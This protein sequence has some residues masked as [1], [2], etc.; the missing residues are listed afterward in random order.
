[1]KSRLL[2]LAAVAV[3]ATGTIIT[4]QAQGQEQLR[5]VGS[6][7]VYPFASY[8]AEELGATT[9]Y[10]TP[11]IESTGSGGGLQ[12]FCAGNGPDTPDIT[13]ASRAIKMS[14]FERCQENGVTDITQITFGSDGI[15]FAQNIDNPPINVTREQITLALAAK[16]PMDGELV[17]NPYTNWSEIDSSLPDREILVYGP[18]TS[19][20]T[21]DAF[22]E[23]VM[24][25]GSENID[26]YDE[27]YTAIR[28]DGVYVPGGEND[29]LLVQRLARNP[30]A[31]GVFGFSFLEEN[32]SVIQG[33]SID[34]VEPKREL[35]SS[36]EYPVA[37]SLF[38]YTKNSH[39][40]DVVAMAPYVDLFLSE[41]LVGG[42]GYL[43]SLG[44][45]PLP[46]D[47]LEAMRAHWEERVT[48]QMSDIE[49]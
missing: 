44:L 26:G 37:R 48:L 45:I 34:G 35:I 18:P 12:L 5:M 7:T 25:Y 22:E 23:I 11:V 24:E 13:N 39:L 40:E 8:V 32:R 30:I 14:E 6:S 46:Q 49:G 16:V 43:K 21:R 19:S 31:F 33:A 17:D 41:Q 29:N 36:G 42:D 20:G 10:D 47:E 4:A 9:E 28:Q 38:F 15:V 3:V 27:A 1:M 2:P